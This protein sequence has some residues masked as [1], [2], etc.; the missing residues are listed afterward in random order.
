LPGLVLVTLPHHV[1]YHK[2]RIVANTN[3]RWETNM[4]RTAIFL[5]VA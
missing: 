2:T 4:E 3:G 1:P 5:W